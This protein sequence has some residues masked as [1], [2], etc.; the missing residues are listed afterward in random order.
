MLL[1]RPGEIITREEMRARLWPAETFVDFDHGLKS[2]IRRLRDALGDSAEGPTFVETSNVEVTG[3]IS[4]ATSTGRTDEQRKRI[5]TPRDGGGGSDFG[6]GNRSRGPR[7]I[8][9]QQ[10]LEV[11]GGYCA[12]GLHYPGRGGAVV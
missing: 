3:Y 6:I 12:H 7:T 8:S 5:R 11:E 9:C 4:C 2:A 10:E 1:E